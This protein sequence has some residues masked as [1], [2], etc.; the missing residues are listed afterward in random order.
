MVVVNEPDREPK[1][2]IQIRVPLLGTTVSQ[3]SP[4][5]EM[6]QLHRG[7]VI[8]ACLFCDTVAIGTMDVWEVHRLAC[9][10]LTE[11]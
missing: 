8:A 6:I 10:A 7:L 2:P 11:N 9:K 5:T 3:C 4:P 1:M